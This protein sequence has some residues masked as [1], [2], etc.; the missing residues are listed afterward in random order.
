M[1]DITKPLF[2]LSGY[3]VDVLKTDLKG[4]YKIV[5]VLTHADGAQDVETWTADGKFHS[6]KLTSSKFD[7]TNDEKYDDNNS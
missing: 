3:K 2:T 6:D 1:I 7:L 4:R 5:G